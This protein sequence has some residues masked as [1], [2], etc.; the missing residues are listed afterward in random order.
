MTIDKTHQAI[1]PDAELSAEQFRVLRQKGTER[2]FSGALW[3]EHRDG[4]YVCAGCDTELFRSETKFDSGTG[5]PSFS[6]PAEDGAV[7]TETDRSMWMTRVEALCST[8]GGHLGH[9]FD[10]GPDPTGQR[11]CINSASLRFTPEG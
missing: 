9:V 10:D 4:R 3:D 2:P 11:Y 6:A 5:W 8:C 7:A 1:R